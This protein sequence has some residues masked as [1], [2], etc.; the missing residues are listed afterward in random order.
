[1]Y[2]STQTERWT[3]AFQPFQWLYLPDAW[4]VSVPPVITMG[5]P[6][7]ARSVRR[8][9]TVDWR[10]ALNDVHDG[11]FRSAQ[12]PLDAQVMPAAWSW[13]AA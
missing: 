13:A 3:S 7:A 5:Q 6:L 11:L 2:E 12:L 9:S 1:M 8:P 10:I 4:P